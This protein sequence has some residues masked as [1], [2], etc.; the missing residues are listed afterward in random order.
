V[1]VP[2]S[3]QHSA[4]TTHHWC[5]LEEWAD[6]DALREL[7]EREFPEQVDVWHEA[8]SRR[9]FL[10]LMGASLA[11]AGLGGCS[12]KPAPPNQIVPYVRQPET[13]IP[14]KPLFFATAMPLAGRT[15]PLLVESHMGRPT[16]VEGNPKHP[17]SMGATNAFAQASVLTLY[18][19][20]R[21]QTVTYQ[22]RTRSWDDVAAM[23]R[24]E[25]EA[26]KQRPTRGQGGGLQLRILTETVTSLTLADQIEALSKAFTQLKWHQ[27]EPTFSP[28]AWAGA[29]LAFGR[30]LATHYR[31]DRA[32]CILS[33]DADFLSCSPGDLRHVREFGAGRR[34]RS[35]Q[36]KMN[37]LYVVESMPTVTGAKADHRWPLRSRDVESFARIVA[38]KLNEKFKPLAGSRVT[39][40]PGKA[41][42]ALVRDL[43]NHRRRSIVIAG[44]GQPAV[45]HALAHAMNDALGNVGQTVSFTTPLAAH[46][47]NQLASLHEL[48]EDIEAGNVDML[49]IL[50]GNPVF[51]APP[52]LRFEERLRNVKQSVHLSLYQDETSAACRWHLP[53]AHYLEAWSDGRATDGSYT[54]S[55]PLIAPLYGGKSA[56]ELLALFL[57]NTH[58]LGYE[59]VRESWR[60]RWEGAKRAGAFEQFWRQAIH[61]GFVEGFRPEPVSVALRDNWMEQPEFKLA[62][63]SGADRLEI[64]FRPDPTILDGRFANNGWLQE[65]PKPITKLTWDNAAFLSPATAQK[66][67]LT[68]PPKPG[69]HG[70]EHGEAAAEMIELRYRDA[71]VVM[72][73]WVL[74][75][76]ADDSV[77]VHFG[78]G[79]THA[80]RVGSGTGFNVYPLRHST[81][82]W[83]G[84]GLEIRPTGERFTLAC[85]Q[86]HQRFDD[87]EPVRAGTLSDYQAKTFV[88]RQGSKGEEEEKFQT[89]VPGHNEDDGNNDADRRLRPLTLYPK[90]E[91]SGN[92]WGMAIDLTACTGCSACVVACQA[93]NNI[94]VVGKEQVLRGREMH[95]LRIDRYY[96]GDPEKSETISTS[97]Q[98]VPC[99]HCENAPCELVCPV[100]ATAHSQ[101]GLNDMVYNRCVGTRYC[102]NNCPYKV[103]RFNFLQFA[104][105]ATAS[106][107]LLRNPDVTVRSRGVM[108]KCTYCVQRIRA[109]E[110]AVE[111]RTVQEKE[112]RLAAGLPVNEPEFETH[113]LLKDGDVV[114]ACQAACPA[115]AIIFGNI[116][117]PGSKVSHAKAEPLDY[118]LLA[119]LNT[120]PRTTYLAALR[121]P[122]P[123]ID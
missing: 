22:G 18:D 122:N 106:L 45:V 107:K 39:A 94:P 3:T 108:E 37:R 78:Y 62:D 120:R 46:P 29:R 17:A 123:E 90:R 55:Q 74:P 97:F 47:V 19:P 79:R 99:M 32:D 26:A 52:D 60:R 98:P 33:L 4:L 53:E 109:A 38:A 81:T 14:G 16:K 36:L 92:Q 61:D 93:E 8:L 95:W 6:S 103:R 5:S 119:S 73:A 1:I 51:T 7:V 113:N 35:D 24:S 43:N 11:L 50:G 84:G 40:V 114:T 21:S 34:V 76:H 105:Y 57:P 56:H 110:I 12:S 71:T 41:V 87:R 117:D 89:L 101:D 111:E 116:N 15:Y 118:G 30:D 85:T 2:L 82:P 70:G 44:D 63:S 96:Q 102:S 59:I 49:L 91:Y 112:R 72:P 77:T 10:T 121:N 20:D 104:D 65:L 75:G 64:V 31:L 54:I 23:I 80:G 115:Q 25:I 88:P 48:V 27:Y 13:I 67:R 68:Y 66:H 42:D 83:H 69:S 100:G 28:G 86:M 9:R 58:Q